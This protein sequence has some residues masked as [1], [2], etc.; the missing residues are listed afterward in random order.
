MI[1]EGVSV[2]DVCDHDTTDIMVK[3]GSTMQSRALRVSEGDCCAMVDSN[4]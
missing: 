4:D 1:A 2:V 3:I